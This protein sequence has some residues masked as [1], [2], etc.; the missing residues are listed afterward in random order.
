MKKII[1]LY[2]VP[3]DIKHI[4]EIESFN[5]AQER[6]DN[7]LKNDAFIMQEHNMANTK[8]FFNTSNELVSYITLFND[9]FKRINKQKLL[10]ENWDL[11]VSEFYPA[12]RLHYIGVNKAYQGQG[13]GYT[14]LMEVF[15]ICIDIAKKSACT[16]L[17]V[18]SFRSSLNF[19]LDNG[20]RNM[21]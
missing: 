5:C 17:S 15:D 11:E 18:E 20:F 7:F 21:G 3:M 1:D 9:I 4:N 8:L 16:F 14:M 2:N 19:Y 13:I 10:K 12:V 6:V